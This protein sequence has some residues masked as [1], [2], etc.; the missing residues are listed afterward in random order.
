MSRFSDF[1]GGLL[2]RRIGILFLSAI[3]LALLLAFLPPTRG[4]I[5]GKD[6]Q[7]LD[8][9]SALALKPIWVDARSE[10]EF[11]QGHIPG[12]FLLD[13]SHWEEGFSRLIS[14]V[15]P[16]TPIIV[17]CSTSSCHRSQETA[18]RL[19]RELGLKPIYTLRGGFEAWQAQNKF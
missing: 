5:N 11:N 7:E 8:I 14:A 18:L 15:Y 10:E 19:K 9:K 12:A 17:Y 16:N 6:V 13:D 4:K 2:L 1:S 3:I